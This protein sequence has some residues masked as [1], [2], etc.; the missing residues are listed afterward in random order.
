MDIKKDFDLKAELDQYRIRIRSYNN[1]EG[2]ESGFYH[3][4][5][6]Q[7][8]HNIRLIETIQKIISEFVNR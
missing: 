6:S 8:Q 1:I 7:H 2:L 5:L 3:L 4:A